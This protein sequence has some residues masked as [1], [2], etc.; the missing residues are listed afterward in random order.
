MTKPIARAVSPGRIILYAIAF[1]LAVLWL[2]PIV[3]MILSSMK[4]YGTPVSIL[5]YAFTPPFTLSNYTAVMERAPIWAWTLNSAI[6]AAIVTG[7]ILLIT[8]MAAYALSILKFKGSKI[9]LVVILSGLM[10]PIEA[11][12]I[13]LYLTIVDL[14]W[15]NTRISLIVPSLAAPMGVVIMKQFYDGIPRDLIEAA[16]IDGSTYIGTWSRICVPLSRSALAA[17]GIFT[18]TNSWNNFLW[19]FLAITSE[20]MMTLPVGIPVFHGTHLEEFTRPMTASVF[21]SVPVLVCFIL[22]QK[23]IVQGI[24]M[25]G[26]KG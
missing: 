25:S 4:P 21:A 13:P 19:P 9:M 3:W 11:I 8:S 10:V 23:Q 22:F 24:A 14:G 17:V 7:C 5:K 6:V 16:R 26:I 18:F 12:V 1:L 20:K 2:F 15:L